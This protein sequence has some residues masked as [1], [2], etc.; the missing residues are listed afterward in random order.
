MKKRKSL[1]SSSSGSPA[2]LSV[3]SSP[4]S[5]E[6]VRSSTSKT[7]VSSNGDHDDDIKVA[8]LLLKAS[9]MFPVRPGQLSG[10]DSRGK[11]CGEGGRC[12]SPPRINY[13]LMTTGQ[14]RGG[15]EQGGGGK[16]TVNNDKEDTSTLLF[17]H[18]GNRCFHVLVKVSLTNYFAPEEVDALVRVRWPAKRLPGPLTEG[19]GGVARMV[20]NSVRGNS[21]PG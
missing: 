11:D 3:S 1:E 9:K 17:H 10:S 7:K 8:L 6:L 14:A 4:S 15:G 5:P 13:V 2:T 12:N 20:I 19:R 16:K 21:P 18:I